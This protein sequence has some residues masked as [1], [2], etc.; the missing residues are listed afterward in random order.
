[1]SSYV[2]TVSPENFL[3]YND[4]DNTPNT[5]NRRKSWAPHQQHYNAS[6]DPSWRIGNGTGIIGAINY[7]SNQGVNAFSFLTM[8]IRGD[9]RNVYP[10]VSNENFLRF[11][12]SKLAQWEIVFEHADTMGM[13]MHFKTAE[14]ENDDLLDGGELGNE[15]KL[16]Y[17]ELI[18]RFGHHLALNWNLAEEITNPVRNIKMFSD[19]F[20][21]IDPYKHIVVTHTPSNS[22][23]YSQLTGYSTFDG[24]SLQTNPTNVFK[25]TLQWVTASAAAGHKWIVTNDEQNSASDGVLPDLVDP[26]HNTIRQQVLWGNIMVRTFIC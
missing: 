1:L 2:K 5:G 8:N 24:P 14:T 15:R 26:N 23:L 6:T 12:V 10:Y 7:L 11:D 20:K 3:A 19:Y 9:D 13:F 22:Q 17:R 16:Y 25:N 21:E 18:A 4:F